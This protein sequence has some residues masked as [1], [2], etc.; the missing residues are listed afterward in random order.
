M[1]YKRIHRKVLE[2]PYFFSKLPQILDTL[3]H[4]HGLMVVGESATGKTEAIKC[5]VLALEMQSATASG[6]ASPTKLPPQSHAHA[7]EK[8]EAFN[9]DSIYKRIPDGS[10]NS[11]ATDMK[12][13]DFGSS[14]SSSIA[15]PTA[16]ICQT[17]FPKALNVNELYGSFDTTTRDW[18]GGALEQAVREA[19]EAKD[20]NVRQWI[21]LDGPVEVVSSHMRLAYYVLKSWIGCLF[22][23]SLLLKVLKCDDTRTQAA[24]LGIS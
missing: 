22:L 10:S 1:L 7:L 13:I 19:S 14:K 24:M 2:N 12:S 11:I 5:L 23:L 6:H 16:C 20:P 18:R 17:I 9:E 4:R 3:E 21:I 8:V 15:N